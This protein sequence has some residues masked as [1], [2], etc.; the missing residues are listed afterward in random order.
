MKFTAVITVKRGVRIGSSIQSFHCDFVKSTRQ[1]LCSL[2]KPE[3]SLSTNE[4]GL[5][6]TNEK[7]ASTLLF[8][9]WTS[10]EAISAPYLRCFPV[11]HMSPALPHSPPCASQGKLHRNSAHIPGSFHW[12]A[13]E[14]GEN[15]PVPTAAAGGSQ[16][17]RLPSNSNLCDCSA[18]SCNHHTHTWW[19]REWTGITHRVA[20]YRAELGC[21]LG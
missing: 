15:E 16:C 2:A 4:E 17:C 7:A 11:L 19:R 10:S 14:H 9:L 8:C 18:G 1:T 3:R 5:L 12:S 6:A 20:N 21:S 13:Q